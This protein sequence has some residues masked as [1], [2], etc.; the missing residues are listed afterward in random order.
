VDAI[1]TQNTYDGVLVGADFGWRTGP[2]DLSVRATA[3]PAYYQADVTR[4]AAKTITF[5]DGRRFAAAGGTYL[6]SSEL[7]DYSATGWTVI[8]EVSLRATY[9]FGESVGL[10]LGTSLLYIP[11][12]ARALPQLPLGIDPD[13]AL[14]GRSGTAAVR[15]MPPELRAIFLSTLSAGL[16]FRF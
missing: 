5:P 11:D 2:W 4:L 15:P 10:T 3:T 8:S 9:W 16:E 7:G 13:R 14:P 6:R 1:R 12:T